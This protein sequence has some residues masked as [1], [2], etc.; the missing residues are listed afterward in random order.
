MSLARTIAV[1]IALILA[2]S[3][4][5]RADTWIVAPGLE[6]A[7]EYGERIREAAAAW[8]KAA[9]EA[10]AEFRGIDDGQGATAEALKAA[11]E[12]EAARPAAEAGRL[13]IILIGHGSYDGRSAKFNVIGPDVAPGDLAGWLGESGRPAAV[14]ALF[15]SSSPFLDLGAGR[16]D[17]LAVSA[18]KSPAEQNY[19]YFAEH[20]AKAL[21]APDSDLDGDGGLSLLEGFLYAA[22]SVE[23][24]FEREGRI[25]TEQ[26][27]IDDSGDGKGTPAAFF[28]GMRA[29]EKPS[30]AKASDGFRSNQWYLRPPPSEKDAPPELLAERDALELEIAKLRDEKASLGEDR[31]Y[32]ELEPLLV[33]LARI[34]ALIDGPAERRENSGPAAGSVE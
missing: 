9:S 24:F 8:Q 31:Y 15:A 20:F 4:T 6:G 34:Y 7:P 13:W 19:A 30:G 2:A 3:A 12:A 23:E 29:A 28:K 10:G 17:R 11:V 32:A 5:A 33:R 22:R 18:T 27:L 1:P 25:A 16:G 26:A 14:L 21:A